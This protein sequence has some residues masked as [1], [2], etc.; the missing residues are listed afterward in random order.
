MPGKTAGG[1][2]LDYEDED[3]E[4]VEYQ[5]PVILR[6]LAADV[7]EEIRD[8]ETVRPLSSKSD[9]IVKHV[10]FLRRLFTLC[11]SYPK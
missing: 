5:A 7:L 1:G 10:K 9:M 3:M 8:V 11:L 6:T 2:E 4:H